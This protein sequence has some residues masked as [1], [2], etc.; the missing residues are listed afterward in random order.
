MMQRDRATWVREMRA[1]ARYRAASL[2]DNFSQISMGVGRRSNVTDR[3]QREN[4]LRMRL[5]ELA[6]QFLTRTTGEVARIRSIID[7]PGGLVNL[8]ALAMLAHRICGTAATFHFED[9]SACAHE[10]EK[11]AAAPETDPGTDGRAC[12]AGLTDQ[13]ERAVSRARR[14]AVRSSA[15]AESLLDW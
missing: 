3:Q 1:D 15:G 12:L 2:V 13:L 9:I 7:A 4:A 14:A 8:D 5:H 6:G 10:L 11:A